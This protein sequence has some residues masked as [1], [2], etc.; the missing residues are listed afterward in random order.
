MNSSPS[1]TPVLSC[2]DVTMAVL[3]PSV[4]SLYGERIAVVDGHER[5]TYSELHRRAAAFAEGLRR[6]G[7][8]AGDAVVL[9]LS[10]SI[11]FVVAYYGILMAEATVTPV[12]PL[13]PV[14]GLRAQ[15]V[16]TGAVAAVGHVSTVDTLTEAARSTGVRLVVVSGT[17]GFDGPAPDG[18]AVAGF[19]DFL[20]HSAVPTGLVAS[21]P[22]GPGGNAVAHLAYTGGT[23]GIPKAV[24]VLQR[25][26]VAN[27]T[28]MTA[29]RAGMLPV[30]DHRGLLVLEPIAGLG[31]A[32]VS[33]GQGSTVV[34]S[35]L[36]HAHA[37]INMS[38]LML[39]G[40]TLVLAG[41][42]APDRMLELIERHRSV[43]LTG[44]PA[45]WHALIGHPDVRKRD[46]SSV[47]VVSSGAAPIDRPTLERLRQ[48]FPE[49]RI[50]EGYGLTEATCAV[51]TAPVSPTDGFKIG[52]VGV[53]LFDTEVEVRS[54]D[55]EGRVLAPGERGELWVRGP[56]VADGYHRRPEATAEQFVDGWLRTGDIGYRDEDGFV[57]IADRAKDML[58][59]KGY[60]VYPR[61]LEDILV[62]HPDVASAAVVGR[63]NPVV[64]QEPIAFVV[65]ERGRSVQPEAVADF[66]SREVLPYKKLRG[67]IVVDSLPVSAAGKVLKTELRDRIG[68]V[69]PPAG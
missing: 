46:L 66:V 6:A 22:S 39:S 27:V 48:S 41:R 4:A 62:R 3:V 47:R 13:Q 15:I 30:V 60:N 20:V 65:A 24:R 35:P 55:A 44:S 17:S 42:F 12:N 34:V 64:G 31:D 50:V 57:F 5:C 56:Q 1:S 10:N 53:P 52:S 69:A 2:P 33:P 45:M 43:Y 19:T 63:S 37:L 68:P 11:D 25:N 29:Q 26:V 18:V 9:H 51:T 8:Q 49:A 28:Q 38:F 59:Y 54:L 14:G 21:H 40:I 36:F 67:V 61:E 16:D 23:T 7:I 58:I 32:A